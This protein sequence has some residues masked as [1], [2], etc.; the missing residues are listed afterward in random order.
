MEIRLTMAETFNFH[1]ILSVD[2]GEI[3][4][5]ENKQFIEFKIC[6]HQY[7]AYEQNI[8]IISVY[9]HHYF[10][11]GYL[12]VQRGKSSFVLMLAQHTY[13]SIFQLMTQQITPSSSFITYCWVKRCRRLCNLQEFRFCCFCLAWNPL[14]DECDYKYLRNPQCF[15][16]HYILLTFY[17]LATLTSHHHDHFILITTV[18]VSEVPGEHFL[19]LGNVLQVVR[20]RVAAVVWILWPLYKK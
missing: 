15:K 5:A 2:I 16:L 6:L 19:L 8:K 20:V 4:L 10:T 3:E 13:M 9:G 11:N 18:D 12:H 1:S 7:I 14:Q 17:F